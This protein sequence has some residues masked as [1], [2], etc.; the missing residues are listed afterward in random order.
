MRKRLKKYLKSGTGEVLGFL[1]ILP[2]LIFFLFIIITIFQ[3]SKVKENLEY[4]VYKVCREIAVRGVPDEEK[5]AK[6]FMEEVESEAFD[7]VKEELTK[8]LDLNNRAKFDPDSLQVKVSLFEDS[9][10]TSEAI[11]S[12]GLRW[13]KGNY[14]M[15][16]VSLYVKA[17]IKLLSRTMTAN[18]VMMIENPGMEGNNYPWF[19]FLD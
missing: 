16:S 4:S 5:D 14:F 11:S 17:P 15:C 13:V 3:T 19:H 10:E 2:T 18:L 6:T 1:F 7:S 12:N 8:T 9:N